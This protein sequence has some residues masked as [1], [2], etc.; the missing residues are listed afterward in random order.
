[1]AFQFPGYRVHDSTGSMIQIRS[2]SDEK[3][4]KHTFSTTP[5]SSTRHINIYQCVTGNFNITMMPSRDSTLRKR[6]Q[7]AVFEISFSC[8]TDEKTN[9]L[10]LFRRF[11]TCGSK[12]GIR[13]ENSFASDQGETSTLGP[14]NHRPWRCHFLRTLSTPNLPTWKLRSEPTNLLL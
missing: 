10:I 7:V 2:T 12:Q 9:R 4:S 3:T 8:R 6:N 14:M 1:M 5:S 13:K 11:G